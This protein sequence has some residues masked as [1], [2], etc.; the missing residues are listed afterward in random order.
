MEL[1]FDQSGLQH[2]LESRVRVNARFGPSDGALVCQRV[3][4]LLAA[5]SLA[6]A[7]Q[8]RTLDLKPLDSS[9]GRFSA[10]LTPRLR[11]RFEAVSEAAPRARGDGQIDLAQV[12]VIRIVG[13]EETQ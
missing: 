8:L 7:A 4:E 6:V 2:T 1:L 10:E 12:R 13:I 5:D 3:C 11:L 9:A